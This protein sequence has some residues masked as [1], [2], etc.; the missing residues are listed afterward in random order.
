[1][2]KRVYRILDHVFLNVEEPPVIGFPP[3]ADLINYG[4]AEF[5]DAD[6]PD[7]KRHRFDPATGG[8]RLATPQELAATEDAETTQKA[9]LTSRQKDTLTTLAYIVRRTNVAAWNALSPADKKTAVMQQA[10][11]WR[12]LRVLVEKL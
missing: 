7:L 4:V 5:A 11:I 2:V 1:M 10:D 8:K 9:E 12:D 6:V 3:R